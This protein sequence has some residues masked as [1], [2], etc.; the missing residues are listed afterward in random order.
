VK[1]VR[2]GPAG[3]K[4]PALRG[5]EWDKGKC[6][7]TFNPLGPWLVTADEVPDPRSLGL[8]LW[9]NG[10]LRQ[11]GTTADMLFG[12]HHLVWYISQFLVLRPGDIVNTSTPA[13]VA[14]GRPGGGY[15]RAGDAMRLEIDGLGAQQQSLGAA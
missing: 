7:E 4:R 14:H 9:V 12:V 5:G 15:L 8:R 13:G 10:E 3:E 2:I 11:D 6:C 1:L